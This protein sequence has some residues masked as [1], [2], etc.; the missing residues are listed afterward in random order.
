MSAVDARRTARKGIGVGR[1]NGRS[2][3]ESVILAATRLFERRGY[4]RTTMQEVASQAGMSVGLIYQYASNKEDLL[5]ISITEILE[6]YSRELPLAMARH[7]DPVERIAAGFAAYCEVVDERRDGVVLAY[8]ETKTLSR[9]GRER[10][11]ALESATTALLTDEVRRGIDQGIFIEVDADLLAH[12]L[13]LLA[14][15]WALKHWHIA[16]RH[17]LERYVAFQTALILRSILVPEKLSQ[18]SHLLDVSEAERQLVV[19]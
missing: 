19:S 17:S 11:K 2:R 14:H 13:M 6:G 18:Y 3:L 15:G 4:H 16:P 10:L 8:R 9:P 12:N 7:T 1:G 5:L